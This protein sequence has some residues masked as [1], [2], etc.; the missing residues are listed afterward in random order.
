MGKVQETLLKQLL[1][2]CLTALFSKFFATVWHKLRPF[3]CIKI[4]LTY[5]AAWRLQLGRT[6]KKLWLLLKPGWLSP[7]Q[8]GQGTARSRPLPSCSPV[9]LPGH[10]PQQFGAHS[11]FRNLTVV[12]L[13]EGYSAHTMG[14][15]SSAIR[16]TWCL[17]VKTLVELAMVFLQ[18]Q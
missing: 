5:F 14:T 17:Q 18:S 4:T 16:F 12:L 9:M 10:T 1:S 8:Q 13:P 2:W 6:A 11:S 7:W 3:T 15:L